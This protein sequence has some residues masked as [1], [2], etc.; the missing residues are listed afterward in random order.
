MS[1]FQFTAGPV[2]PG[3]LAMCEIETV[4]V[5]APN[6][7]AI[8]LVELIRRVDGRALIDTHPQ[9]DRLSLGVLSVTPVPTLT[10]LGLFALI[11]GVALVA[12]RA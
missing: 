3:Q 9:N 11:F 5:A 12:R 6:L 2:Q 4:G 8:R 1:G 10:W 7:S